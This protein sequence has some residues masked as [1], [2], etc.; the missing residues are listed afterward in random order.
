ME[1]YAGALLLTLAACAAAPAYADSASADWNSTAGFSSPSQD[2]N[3]F[4]AAQVIQLLN[5]GSAGPSVVT[6]TMNCA[7]PGSCPT[8]GTQENLSGVTMTTVNGGSGISIDTSTSSR[9]TQSNG[10]TIDTK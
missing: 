4:N 9:A 6:N 5:H 1:G 8:A 10:I 7:V 2:A 3:A